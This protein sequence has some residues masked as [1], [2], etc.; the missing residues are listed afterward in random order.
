MHDPI[1]KLKTLLFKHTAT[2][3]II[4]CHSGRIVTEIHKLFNGFDNR[5]SLETSQLQYV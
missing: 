1:Q 4:H 2:A 5:T 3:N